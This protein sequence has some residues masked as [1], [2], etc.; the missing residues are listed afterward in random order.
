MHNFL[1]I[2]GCSCTSSTHSNQDPVHGLFLPF[3]VAY[4]WDVQ[5][6][7]GNFL[8]HL[9]EN[10][11]FWTLNIDYL[12]LW[13]HLRYRFIKFL[14]WK[15]W[16]VWLNCIYWG[17]AEIVLLLH[18]EAIKWKYWKRPTKSVKVILKARESKNG[19][20]LILLHLCDHLV[21]KMKRIQYFDVSRS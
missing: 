8:I 15:L 1:K 16:S 21:S 6:L 2:D 17:Q 3:L 14:I 7:S 10:R 18:T 9:K 12:Y 20:I 4:S 19:K 13:R 11:L 5:I